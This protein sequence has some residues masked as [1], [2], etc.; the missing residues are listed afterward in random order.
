LNV[1]EIRS[2][3]DFIFLCFSY[4]ISILYYF[5]DGVF[6]NDLFSSFH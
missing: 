1:H 2:E 4:L 3:R 6:I 5:R